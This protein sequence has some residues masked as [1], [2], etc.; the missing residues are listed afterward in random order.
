MG[1]GRLLEDGTKEEGVLEEALD[2]FDEEGGKVPCMGMDRGDGL[3]VGQVGGK[4][5]GLREGMEVGKGGRV[6]VDVILVGFFEF[7]YL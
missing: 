3:G 4:G 1:V 7:G 6:F 2:R 5:G